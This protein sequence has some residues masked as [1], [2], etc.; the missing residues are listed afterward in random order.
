MTAAIYVRMFV[1]DIERNVG[2]AT[3]LDLIDQVRC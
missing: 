2:G 1:M 3:N